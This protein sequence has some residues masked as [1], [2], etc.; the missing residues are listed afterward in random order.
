MNNIYYVVHIEV[1]KSVLVNRMEF[2]V[3]R[4]T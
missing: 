2:I 1:Y 3:V 4:M